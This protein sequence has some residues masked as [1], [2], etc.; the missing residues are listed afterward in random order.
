MHSLLQNLP[1][2]KLS[3]KFRI[4]DTSLFESVSSTT[5][6]KALN[7]FFSLMNLPETEIFD[8]CNFESIKLWVKTLVNLDYSNFFNNI[9]NSNTFPINY[10][11]ENTTSISLEENKIPFFY[12]VYTFLRLSVEI[13]HQHSPSSFCIAYALSMKYGLL[14]CPE[15]WLYDSSPLLNSLILSKTLITNYQIAQD[16]WVT[17]TL[18]LNLD[19]NLN[20][21]KNYLFTNTFINNTN[22][23]WTLSEWHEAYTKFIQLNYQT[24][25]I[26]LTDKSAIIDFYANTMND[27]LYNEFD[28]MSS[29]MLHFVDICSAD[30]EWVFD[31]LPA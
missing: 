15:V 19:L 10:N 7:P 31:N 11:F 17:S 14:T 24:N 9:V 20:V 16:G 1:E 29:D 2:G 13:L 8:P 4:L 6:L 27:I 12:R 21:L 26:S 22:L 23:I 18:N 5:C 3:P 25:I 28:Q 30:T